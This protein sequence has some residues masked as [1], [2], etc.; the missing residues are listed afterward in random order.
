MKTQVLV[1]F[2]MTTQGHG[3][4]RSATR[5]RPIQR[6]QGLGTTVTVT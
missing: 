3:R 6:L 2:S 1:K 5:S 4:G